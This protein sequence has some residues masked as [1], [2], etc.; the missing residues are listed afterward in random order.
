MIKANIFELSLPY[1][2][3]GGRRVRVFVPEHE[4]GET[5]PVIYMTDGHNLFSR[6]ATSTGRGRSR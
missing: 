5:L 1:S 3:K 4:D 2:D 6:S